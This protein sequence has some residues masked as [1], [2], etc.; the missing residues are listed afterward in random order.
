MAAELVRGQNHPLPHTGLT[1][2]VSA[3]GP[4]AVTVLLADADG[5]VRGPEHVTYPGAPELPGVRLSDGAGRPQLTV[6]LAA[7]P[8]GVERLLIALVLP[9]GGGT[10]G[11]A[12][13]PFTAVAGPDGTDVATFTLTG[14]TTETAVTALE[15]YLRGGTW[16]VRAVGQGYAGG[17]GAMLRDHGLTGAD[18][19]AAALVPAPAT[20]GAVPA[21]T[22]PTAADATPARGVPLNIAHPR[23]PAPGSTPPPAAAPSGA[24][25]GPSSSGPS[26]VPPT[27]PEAPVAGDAAGWTM[28]ERLYNQVWGIFEDAARSAA[29]YRSAVEYA[30]HRQDQ[31]IEAL[32]AD[33]RSR[34]GAEAELGRMQARARRD[35]LESRAREVL[36]RDTGQLLAEVAV[37]EA[38]MPAPMAGWDNPAWASW[39]PPAE[40]PYGVRI[41][42]LHLPENPGLKV[43]LLLRLPLARGL[44]V[45]SGSAPESGSGAPADPAELKAA[46]G[47]LAT[48]TAARLLAC[49]RPGGLLLHVID[50][51]GGAGP[52]LAPL[53]RAGLTAGPPASAAAGVAA[54]LTSLVERV[55]LVQMARRAGAADALPPHVDPADRLLLVHD[56]PYGFDDG[57][58]GKLRYL[59]EE[60]PAVG[61]HLLVVADRAEASA[62]GPV[63][64]PFWRGLTRMAPVP[65]EY[66]ADPW[67]EHLWTYTPAA[68]APGSPALP[69]LLDRIARTGRTAR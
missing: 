38:A 6:D 23:R 54:L 1:V 20:P 49:H 34:F 46:A 57:T 13:A 66:L 69:E 30:D 56:F 4:H 14:L 18:A 60:G 62:Y 36:D 59:A 64:D 11:S 37:V 33:P 58:V 44:W 15:L 65:Q 52:A 26:S 5:R 25:G 51:G 61:V 17:A 8:P 27:G 16:K 53:V 7:L 10:F 28:D 29:A 63:L 12:S 42:D 2:R 22:P 41:G 50:P 21:A 40:P 45:D 24:P 35:D 19:L 68:P 39:Q 55:D 47:A 31:E 3:A 9:P 43:P 67:V 32:L 48:A